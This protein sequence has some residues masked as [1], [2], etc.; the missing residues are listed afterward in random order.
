MVISANCL[1][2]REGGRGGGR[3]YNKNSSLQHQLA[4]LL[5]SFITMLT[6]RT[7]SDQTP[8]SHHVTLSHIC[9]FRDLV[10]FNQLES[11]RSG[12]QN[13]QDSF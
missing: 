13:Q 12:L 11:V 2:G 7:R 3:M 9:R 5:T 6:P 4:H 1:P 8:Y 10:C